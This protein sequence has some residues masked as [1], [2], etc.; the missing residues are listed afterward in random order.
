MEIGNKVRVVDGEGSLLAGKTGK[1]A[2]VFAD[3]GYPQVN[4]ILDGD[5]HQSAFGEDELEVLDGEDDHDQC[6]NPE[7]CKGN[8]TGRCFLYDGEME[9]VE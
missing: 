7:F 4:V 9:V 1:V 5:E 2:A 6:R 8:C 3:K